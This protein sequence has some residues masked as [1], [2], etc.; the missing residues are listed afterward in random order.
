MCPVRSVDRPHRRSV[1][2][3]LGRRSGSGTDIGS[4]ATVSSPEKTSS[5]CPDEE[6]HCL[7]PRPRPFSESPRVKERTT[8]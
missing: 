7:G 5:L 3:V 2:G 1:K 4:Q 6:G 8:T